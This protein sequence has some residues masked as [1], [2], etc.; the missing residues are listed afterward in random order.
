MKKRLFITSVALSLLSSS[1]LHA[2]DDATLTSDLRTGKA[3]A[4]QWANAMSKLSDI[5][6]RPKI[7]EALNKRKNYPKQSLVLL[8]E[9]PQ[10]SV[11]LGAIELLEDV[12][13]GDFG[14]NPWINPWAKPGEKGAETNAEALKLWKQW[15]SNDAKVLD[16][17]SSKLS[18]EK[19]QLYIQQL[20]SDDRSRIARA[21]RMLKSDNFNAVAS[22]QQFLTDHPELPK[23]KA[24]QLK[25]AQYELVLTKASQNYAA[26]LSRDLVLGNRDQQIEAL[27]RL[28][29]LGLITIPIIRD[30][31][32]APD[33]LI[34]ETAIDAI[35]T[36][37]GAQTLPFVAER[38]KQEKDINVIHVGIKNLKDIGGDKSLEI[39]KTFLN[40]KD[41]DLVIASISAIGK[42]LGGDNDDPFGDYGTSKSKKKA[43][44]ESLVIIKLLKDSRWRVRV[45]A[46]Q[47]TAKQK[48]KE[49]KDDI[50]YLLENDN[51][52]FVR[53]HTIKT[54]VALNIKE[55]EATLKKLYLKNDEMVGSLTQAFIEMSDALPPELLK[56]LK[57][58]DPDTIISSLKAFS[59]S[60]ED[61]LKI[62]ADFS[63][64]KN[65][66]VACA[67]LRLLCNSDSKTGNNFVANTLTDALRTKKSEQIDAIVNSIELP[68]SKKVDPQLRQLKEGTIAAL[69]SRS[70]TELDPLYDAFLKPNNGKALTII[71][72]AGKSAT[73]TG[74]LA[75]LITTLY[76]IAV[77][78][79]SSDRAFQ[80]ALILTKSGD[81]RGLKLIKDSIPQM[82]I[83]KRASLAEAL[84]NPR[85]AESVPIL[86]AL[87]QDQSSEIRSAAIKA[88]FSHEQNILMVYKALK[89]IT[90]EGSKVRGSDAY[91]YR[92]ES[93]AS[94]AGT[95][96]IF[97][98]W[99]LEQLN[100]EEVDD[101]VRILSLILIQKIA[102]EQ[103]SEL[104]ARFTSS[105]NPWVRRAAWRTLGIMGSK[106]QIENI[107]K[108]M[109]DSNP[110]VRAALANT[111]TR[112]DSTWSNIF[113]DTK[114]KEDQ[115][116][117]SDKNMRR[118]NPVLEK[119]L[120]STANNDPSAENRFEAM[121]S[122]LS[123]SRTID[124]Q[125]FTNL[126]PKQ[127]KDAK[128]TERL[129][130]L[131]QS[132]YSNMG[133]G[134]RPLLAYVDFKTINPSYHDRILKHFASSGGSND[135]TASAGFTTFAGLAKT[136]DASEEPQHLTTPEKQ[137]ELASTR[138]KL[139]VVFFEKAG[140]KKCLQVE[141]Y[142]KDMKKDFPL[143]EIKREY[144]DQNEGILLNNHLSNKLNVPS[145]QIRKA[146]AVFTSE[147][148]L[149]GSKINPKDLAGLLA[150]TMISPEKKEW[151]GFKSEKEVIAAKQ[152]TEKAY[153]DLTLPIV[154]A[155]G[156]L[157]G[158]NPCAFATIIFF[159]SYLT[160][161]KR[162]AKEIF[163]VGFAFIL[164]V[165]LA[166]LSFGLIFS[167]ALKYLTEN[168]QYQWV[169][170][171][172]NYV[173]AGFALLVAVL[174][175]R[176]W[177]RARQGRLEDMTLQLPSFLKKK[178]RGVIRKNSK[179]SLYVLAAFG[180]GIVIS[181]LELACTG[182][183]YAPIIYK[184]NEGSQDAVT[185][186]VIYNIA[187]VLP[188][189][190]IFAL[191]MTGMKSNAL[192]NFQ[193]NHTS[194]IKL[195]TAILFF[196]LA[197]IL[198]FSGQI[199]VLLEKI[200]PSV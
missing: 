143:L 151:F 10:L 86:E 90:S 84:Y 73:S 7:E 150:N 124:L 15:A 157:D 55:A 22:I 133:K 2:Q 67:A 37:G 92:T 99:C 65:Q 148:F 113:S 68:S 44:P 195:M 115:Q 19:V 64:N 32:D 110:Q 62:L 16:K 125:K 188:L 75:T 149:V 47:Y 79:A 3:T 35:L 167:E 97:Y 200:Y 181:V 87:L 33:A 13:G 131:I 24:A 34:R 154:I 118:L 134:M 136:S 53:H 63:R 17:K 180:S 165:F 174:S 96:R 105:K 138:E 120:Q 166:Y 175:L 41:E 38:L 30:Y 57:T 177:W 100:K 179:S 156:L 25:Q 6:W 129:S 104:I 60:D 164:A 198:L 85:Q 123:H 20:L 190:V 139:V 77:A 176:D 78:D 173:F 162:S 56:H 103:D 145:T 127:P 170:N 112:A 109:N 160:V 72:L 122:L 21:I 58:R 76:E 46:L 43:S 52:E 116:Y 130:R 189:I 178:I 54:A 51:D 48:V 1:I 18:A 199:S 45:A 23:N 192:I 114:L 74:G 40:H 111:T 117:F 158:I 28:K 108:L 128:V 11:R 184:I 132:N 5:E 82:P 126:I 89:S 121:L 71:P 193:T 152:E 102:H 168:T 27:S 70:K 9:H 39:I 107:S 81:S 66:D 8:L 80:I 59:S 141:G 191:A 135:K 147:G 171:A 93:A 50:I 69:P 12:S 14:Y 119:A 83:S 91:T 146:P 144:V 4:E 187:F 169:R 185:M 94:N 140:C 197:A 159:L 95:M 194:K 196:A 163:M 88:S 155:G 161:A 26:Q 31:I 106:W 172:L 101:E 153:N 36:V 61:Q 49:A 29:K 182:Q 98:S 186:L 42:L 183:V 137:L 142:L